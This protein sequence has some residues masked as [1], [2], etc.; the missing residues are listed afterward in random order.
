MYTERNWIVCCKFR[1]VH[2][3][4]SLIQ[5]EKYELLIYTRDIQL[6][7]IVKKKNNI[8]HKPR[9]MSNRMV[10]ALQVKCQ[11]NE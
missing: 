8:W 7:S 10:L 3:L 2:K 5:H 6:I 9:K 1:L 4:H 11:P